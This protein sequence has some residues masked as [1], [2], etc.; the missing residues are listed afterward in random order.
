[1]AEV[2]EL[3]AKDVMSKKLMTLRK[4]TPVREAAEL[5]SSNNIGGAPVVDDEGRLIGIVTE[6]DLIMQDVKLRFPTYV[7]LLNG[8]IY[9]PTSLQRFETELR[10]A[11]GARVGDVMSTDVITVD[12]D[13]TV[14]DIATLMVDEDISRVP[15]MSGGKLVGIV[16]KGDLVRAISK[17]R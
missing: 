11:V 8:Y 15:V 10:K 2:R 9:L 17:E 13:T 3:T 12:E 1:M 4:E 14:E 7:E 5:L 16:T 6:S